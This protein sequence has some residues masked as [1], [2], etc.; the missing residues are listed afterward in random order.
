MRRSGPLAAFAAFGVFWGAWGVLLPDAKEQ[1]GASVAELG[2]ALLAIGLAALPAMILTGRVVDRVGPRA[3]P[4]ALVLFGVAV[5]LPGLTGSV[6][7]LA[8]ALALVGATSGALDV[9]I[10]VAASSVEASGGPRI[11]QIAHALFSAGFL[12][13]AIVVGLAREA[14]ADPLPVLA[15]AAAVML[16]VGAFNR[17]HPAAPTRA[18][19]RRRLVFSRRL[20]L[21]GG[22]CAVAFVV[23]SGI[24]NWSALFLES[25]L[26]ASPAVSAL[27]PGLFAAAMVAGRSLGQGLEGRMADRTLLVGG[28][29][30]AS[31][32]LVLAALAPGIPAAIAG[33]LLG[34]AGVSV[35]APTLFGA[36]GRGAHEAERGSAVASVTTLAYLGF[37]TGPP[38]IGAVSGAFDLRAGMAMLGGIGVLLALATASLAGDA[39]PVRRLQHPSRGEVP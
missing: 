19:G 39:L 26:D 5:V 36:A 17:G 6:W 1:V 14:G 22:L 12:V 13:A 30:T 25:E 18:P 28:A 16:A 11:M 8:L 34:G 10:N 37:L 2:A 27:G 15:A 24:E 32:G 3:L 33:F 31:C 21:L 29:L 35:A 23:E 4:P 38:L 20:L 7:Q 9:V